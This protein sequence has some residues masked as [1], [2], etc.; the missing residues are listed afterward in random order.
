MAGRGRPVGYRMSIEARDAISKRMTG[1]KLKEETKKK[2]RDGLS[3]YWE[4]N[5]KVTDKYVWFLYTKEG[6]SASEI[7]EHLE[8]SYQYIYK[9]L[10]R[11]EIEKRGKIK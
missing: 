2:I 7:A 6:L 1:R 9:I 8:V 5:K 11:V 3:R 4:E 10:R